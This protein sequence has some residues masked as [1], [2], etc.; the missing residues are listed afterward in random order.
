MKAASH[1][2]SIFMPSR[3]PLLEDLTL[4][5]GKMVSG[6]WVHCYFK[7]PVFFNYHTQKLLNFSSLEQ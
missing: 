5:I 1:L 3:Y 6:R 7:P 2:E 4:P